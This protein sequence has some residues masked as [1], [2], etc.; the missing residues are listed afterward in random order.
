MFQPLA[1]LEGS[2]TTDGNGLDAQ[3]QGPDST[4]RATSRRPHRVRDRCP[5]PCLVGL[6]GD[7][8]TKKRELLETRACTKSNASIMK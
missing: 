5:R 1:A 6:G 7:E 3:P 2:R 8:D 4:I